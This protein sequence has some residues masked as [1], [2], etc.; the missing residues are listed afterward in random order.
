M[1]WPKVLQLATLIV[2]RCGDIHSV[3][4]NTKI[5]HISPAF[6]DKS[7]RAAPGIEP[8][9]SRTRSENHATGPCSRRQFPEPNS[10]EFA[11][12]ART[13]KCAGNRAQFNGTCSF[14][15]GV[16]WGPFPPTK[17]M[18]NYTVLSVCRPCAGWP[19]GASTPNMLSGIK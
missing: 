2:S 16:C 1:G 4:H 7:E 6:A 17:Q 8:G 11:Q 19:T 14:R 12:F 18:S 10:R 3:H 5:Y 9:A 13:H 15:G